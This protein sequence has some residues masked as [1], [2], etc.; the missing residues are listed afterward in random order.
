MNKDDVKKLDEVTA[1]EAAAETQELAS[2]D[3]D[4][5]NAAGGSVTWKKKEEKGRK[6]DHP[7]IAPFRSHD[8]W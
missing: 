4:K 8:D 5:V 3:L 6:Y 1:E 7:L 2:D